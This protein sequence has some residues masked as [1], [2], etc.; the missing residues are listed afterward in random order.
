MFAK[1]FTR[2]GFSV[3]RE[4]GPGVLRISGH[5]VDLVLTARLDPEEQAGSSEFVTSFGDLT[6]L[7]DVRDSV[8]DEPLLR[9]LD[10]QPISR[11]P[12]LTRAE[13]NSTG[14]NLSAQR[15]VFGHQAL[16]LQQEIIEL[17]Q[18]GRL[19]A[20][21]AGVAAPAPAAPPQD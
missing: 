5:V 16:L 14:A 19:P 11:Y 6:L 10:R 3:V 17:R 9:T 21:P 12:L 13:R 8:R 4:P 7:I 1:Q 20:P 2:G 18:L 15:D